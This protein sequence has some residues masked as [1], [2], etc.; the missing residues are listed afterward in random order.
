MPEHNHD[1]VWQGRFKS[2]PIQQDDPLLTVFRY[3]LLNPVRAKLVAHGSGMTLVASALPV[4]HR[5]S[6]HFSADR[7]I[8]LK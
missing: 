1:H 2:F 5:S 3:V 8:A 4:A 6:P 7:R